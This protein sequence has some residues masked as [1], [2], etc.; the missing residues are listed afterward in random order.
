MQTSS[1]KQMLLLLEV[2]IFYPQSVPFNQ[3]KTIPYGDPTPP[4]RNKS[5]P[6]LGPRDCSFRHTQPSGERRRSCD[7]HTWRQGRSCPALFVS[8]GRGAFDC[9][10]EEELM[11]PWCWLLVGGLAGR[12]MSVSLRFGRT[13]G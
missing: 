4:Q 10:T 7:F 3:A 13:T 5:L 8:T 9:L 6:V 2:E 1:Y 12:T 11:L